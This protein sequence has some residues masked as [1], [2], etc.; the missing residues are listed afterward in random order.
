MVFTFQGYN[1]QVTD[2]HRMFVGL[3]IKRLG[4]AKHISFILMMSVH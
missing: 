1:I 2:M 3:Y 4:H